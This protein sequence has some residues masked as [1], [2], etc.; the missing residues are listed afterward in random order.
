MI[1]IP[2]IWFSGKDW[3]TLKQGQ[4]FE[5]YLRHAAA[6]N[7]V[8]NYSTLWGVCNVTT[9]GGENCIYD[10]QKEIIN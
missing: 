1:L 4:V 3:F 7:L 9:V 5:S 8:V 10:Y 2:S 6:L